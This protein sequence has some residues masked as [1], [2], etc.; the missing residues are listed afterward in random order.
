MDWILRLCRAKAVADAD[1]PTCIHDS[2]IEVSCQRGAGIRGRAGSGAA[3]A[4]VLPAEVLLVLF[5]FLDIVDLVRAEAVRSPVCAADVSI[6]AV[7]MARGTATPL[8]VVG[9][10]VVP[11]VVTVSWTWRCWGAGKGCAPRDAAR[12]PCVRII[13]RCVRVALTAG[14]PRVLSAGIQVC[15]AWSSVH[16]G[17][18]GMLW[19]QLFLHHFHHLKVVD[20]PGVPRHNWRL[21]CAREYSLE[22][23]WRCGRGQLTTL[24]GHSGT[25]TCLALCGHEVVSG[26]DDGS[27]ALWSL[28]DQRRRRSLVDGSGGTTDSS[29]VA[30]V[31]GD[32]GSVGSVSG[33][34]PSSPTS[35]PMLMQQHHKQTR[36]VRWRW[37]GD[38]ALSWRH[39][40][41]AREGKR[42]VLRAFCCVMRVVRCVM[43]AV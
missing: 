31:A 3:S 39:R 43:R 7:L 26:G 17:H 28:M 18:S 36:E 8:A 38:L 15:V 4:S 16:R 32:L 19:H 20:V 42:S 40:L 21:E 10:G 29:G 9:V 25:V 34:S 5:Q 33:S 24:S 12:P 37:V 11:T 30:G 2:S 6:C 41:V 22:R 1:L 14:A 27:L 35:A 23:S 13:V